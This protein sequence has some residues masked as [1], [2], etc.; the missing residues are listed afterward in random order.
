MGLSWFQT[1]Y[2][3]PVP[4]DISIMTVSL[5]ETHNRNHTGIV[6]ELCFAIAGFCQV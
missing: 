1:R 6:T 3:C 2:S 4:G 5:L